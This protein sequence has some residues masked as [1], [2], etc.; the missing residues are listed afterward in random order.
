MWYSPCVTSAVGG[1]P[2]SDYCAVES[3]P[4][5]CPADCQPCAACPKIAEATLCTLMPTIGAC[6]CANVEI[7]PDPCIFPQG[8]GCLCRAYLGSLEACPP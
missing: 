4:G 1:P 6:D 5:Q 2:V 3:I 8:C 7:G